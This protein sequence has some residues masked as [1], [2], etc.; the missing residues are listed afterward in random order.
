MKAYLYDKNDYLV[1][2][3]IAHPETNEKEIVGE[4][5]QFTQWDL[6]KKPIEKSFFANVKINWNGESNFYFHGQDYHEGYF[7][8]H[9]TLMGV[10]DYLFGMK[11]LT[12]AYQVMVDY[13]GGDD[14]IFERDEYL[15]L[16]KLNLLKDYKIKLG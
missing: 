15:K 6:D 12:F 10:E 7:D 2:V 4:I 14:K 13:F 5:Q 9:Y 11:L 16:K 3:F 8:S 1:A